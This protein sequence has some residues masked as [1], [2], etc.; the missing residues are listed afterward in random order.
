MKN[1]SDKIKDLTDESH[2]EGGFALDLGC[3]E[4]KFSILMAQ[5][6]LTVDAVDESAI[7]LNVLRDTKGILDIHTF[8]EDVGRFNIPVGKYKTAVARN[9]FPFIKD[10]EIV[11]KIITSVATGLTSGGKFGLTL[12]GPKD[13]WA[14]NPKM[15]F[16]EH[17][18]ILSTLEKA[19]L[20][21]I[22]K[23]EYEGEG[24]TM[25]NEIKH[26]HIHTY[27]TRKK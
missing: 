22:D 1:I 15:S 19:G 18:E 9:I 23:E 25:A 5:N 16:F 8:C 14:P 13:A 12:F 10:K 26:W 11:K 2:P 7:K 20:E 4:G 6:G 17:S 21:L 24:Y 27:I 3:G